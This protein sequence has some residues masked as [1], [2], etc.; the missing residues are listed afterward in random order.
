MDNVLNK[1]EFSRPR[2]GTNTSTSTSSQSSERKYRPFVDRKGRIHDTLVSQGVQKD[3]GG[4]RRTPRVELKLNTK[5]GRQVVVEPERGFDLN[6]ALRV[7]STNLARNRV[8]GQ[9]TAQKFH[10][11][12]GQVIKNQRSERWRRLFKFSFTKTVEKVYRMKAQG[13]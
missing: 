4:L 2:T 11:R 7:M 5:L 12:R 13:W 1:L 6:T 8:R 10:V 3:V 9:K